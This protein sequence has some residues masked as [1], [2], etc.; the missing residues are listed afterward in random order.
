MSQKQLLKYSVQILRHL[1]LGRWESSHALTGPHRYKDSAFT[2]DAPPPA[3]IK[4]LYR[5]VIGSW[6][7]TVMEGH[8]DDLCNAA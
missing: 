8:S 1:T 7:P 5:T 2:G 3:A 6:N 4:A